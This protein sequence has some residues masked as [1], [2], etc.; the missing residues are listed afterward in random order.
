MTRQV[1]NIRRASANP[2]CYFISGFQTRGSNWFVFDS[3][4]KR[5]RRKKLLLSGHARSLGHVIYFD[6]LYL[7]ASAQW[8]SWSAYGGCFSYDYAVRPRKRRTRTCP[9]D[10]CVGPSVSYKYDCQP[11][12][13]VFG[14]S[15]VRSS[16][17]PL[18]F[19]PYY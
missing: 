2:Q 10:T 7:L 16:K 9:D 1:S 18:S 6:I 4:N 5:T 19:Y 11:S 12:G 13:N 17:S 15:F 14:K 8:G 3:E